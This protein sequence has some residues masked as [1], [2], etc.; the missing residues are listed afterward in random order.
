MAQK[1]RQMTKLKYF[2]IQ[3]NFENPTNFAIFCHLVRIAQKFVN[4]LWPNRFSYEAEI[5][6]VDFWLSKIA[7]KNI[8]GNLKLELESCGDFNS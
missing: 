7:R 2:R 4:L 8:W 3:I 5:L 6:R 1:G